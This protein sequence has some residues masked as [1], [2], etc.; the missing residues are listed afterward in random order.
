MTTT[1][2][3]L[4]N[5]Q[6]DKNR[7][8]T[9]FNLDSSLTF[10]EI[11][12]KAENGEIGGGGTVVEEKDVNFFDYDGT[13]VDSYTTSE[14]A[15]LTTLPN[16][17]S[18]EG[19]TAQGWNWTLSD[20]QNYV[21][22]YGQLDIGQMYTT[23]DGATRIYISLED[24][25]LEPYLGFSVNGS[26]TIDWGDGTS[27]MVTGTSVAISNIIY[28]QHTYAQAGKYVI[29]LLSQNKIYFFGDSSK[30]SL[31]LTKN[32]TSGSLNRVYQ[33]AIVKIELGSNAVLGSVK[34]FDQ[35]FSLETITIPKGLTLTAYTYTQLF[36]MCYSLKCVVIPTTVTII[37]DYT[38]T[39]CRSL[40]K[41][42]LPKQ[43]TY[44]GNYVFTQCNNLKKITMSDN[45]TNIGSYAFQWCSSI[46]E[47]KI[48]SSVTVFGLSAFQS[49]FS[50]E[51]V[52][53][54]GT[55]NNVQNFAFS[56]CVSLKAVK[57]PNSLTTLNASIFSGCTCLNNVKIPS[58]VTTL[59]NQVFNNCDGLAYLDFSKHTSIPSITSS[60]IYLPADAKIIVPDDLYDDWKVAT[61][62]SNL[63]SYII[64]KSEWDG[65]GNANS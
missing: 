30:S 41:I 19:L 49:C 44:I 55:P 24:G 63:A 17:P 37:P 15:N 3:Y 10:T 36:G 5:L 60:S 9:V 27:Q 20:A 33:N 38:F 48:P 22:T 40:N 2:D 43:T 64:K 31:I 18:H 58:T 23:D 53:F 26:V 4:T 56:S 28:T 7:L 6:S 57:L 52:E 45:T 1:S 50:L 12:E 25:R 21:A 39:N 16:N 11:A 59:G 32:A 8:T 13:L 14:F 62:W 46:G 54:F 51:K 47:I 29:S 35:C 42:I 61:N 65:S 34:V